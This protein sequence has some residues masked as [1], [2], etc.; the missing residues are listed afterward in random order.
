MIGLD[1]ADIPYTFVRKHLDGL[2]DQRDRGDNETERIVL[3]LCA[4]DLSG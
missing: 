3:E 1:D 4:D 2:I